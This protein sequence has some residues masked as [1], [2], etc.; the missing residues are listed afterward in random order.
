[1]DSGDDEAVFAE[2]AAYLGMAM[3]LL[4][5]GYA[6]DQV[7]RGGLDLAMSAG[8]V[9]NL[10]GVAVLWL[11]TDKPIEG[12]TLLTLAT[13]HGLTVADLLVAVPLLMALAVAQ[14]VRVSA[15]EKRR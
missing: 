6:A 3:L 11:R 4:V 9:T 15:R 7:R 5:S 12:A 1:M 14:S 2:L 10:L 8:L 13:R